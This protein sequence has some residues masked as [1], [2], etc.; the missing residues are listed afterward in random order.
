MT[1]PTTHQESAALRKTAWQAHQHEAA[2][3]MTAM[4]LDAVTSPHTKRAYERALTDFWDWRISQAPDHPLNKALVNRYKAELEA[5][6]MGAASINQRLSA[7]RKM[8]REAADNAL[9]GDQIATGISRASGIRQE[10][11]RTGNWLTRREAQ[12]LLNTP[13]TATL[14]G[15][16]DRTILAVLIGCGLRRT[17]VA[18]LRF[19]HI[20]QREGRWAIVDLIGKRNKARTVPMP[21]WAKAAVDA[22]AV[23]AGLNLGTLAINE[24]RVFRSVNKGGSLS[25]DSITP[26]AIRNV[27]AAY[28]ETLGHDIA[29][30]DLRRT[31]AKLARAGG[32]D[33][34][35]I[36]LSLGHESIE[37]TQ[38]YLGTKQDFTDA[39]CDRLGISL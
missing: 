14:K 26:Q 31:F 4:V 15:L 11:Q 36:S 2:E 30:H 24:G 5:S 17:E 39:P 38:R 37:V 23:A 19:E 35:Q 21:S 7:I 1:L 34:E 13:D 8:A 33:L 22:W 32:A 10:G 9:L 3:K 25:G 27:V 16:R 28:G 12:D 18:R 6:G 20:Q 29:P